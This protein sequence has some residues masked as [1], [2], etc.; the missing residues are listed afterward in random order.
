MKPSF[1]DKG[2]NTR[3]ITLIENNKIISDDDR[4]AETLDSFFD[5]TVRLKK[6]K[7]TSDFIVKS[8]DNVNPIDVI[9]GKYACHPSILKISEAVINQTFLFQNVELSEVD[10]EIM[11]LKTNSASDPYGIP[12][13][14][15]KLYSNICN[16]PLKD[17]VNN[18]I[19][20]SIFDAKLKDANIT[21]VHKKDENTKTSNY[22]PISVL[23]VVA[24]LIERSLHK[25]IS[26]YI[27]QYLSKFL[28]G[29]RKG[30]NAQ[31]ALIIMLEEWRTSFDN[32]GFSGAIL[33]DISKA[34]D[35]LNHELLIAKLRGVPQGSVLGPLLF[36]IYINDLLFF[37]VNTDVCNYADDTTL[38]TCDLSLS[39]LM[40]RLA[41]DA[42]IAVEWFAY[43]NMK[44][45]PDKCHILTSGFKHEVMIANIENALVIEA[46]KVRLLGINMT[47]N[48]HLV[49][50]LNPFAKM[51]EK[52]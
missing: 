49:V 25:Q 5:E 48:Y 7:L 15:I 38:Y 23:P 32:N 45:N 44:L 1:S 6:F 17:I 9:I 27:D 41:K 13:K 4:V 36:N 50:T 42:S 10:E 16:E 40:H 33:M 20:T 31:Q 47:P 8:I 35:T 12:S 37:V 34:F 3:K 43:N 52:N 21:P 11:H 46:Q 18:C 51:L 28:C 39:S 14:I 22:R 29:Y 30:Y 19:E 2:V 26:H 24:K